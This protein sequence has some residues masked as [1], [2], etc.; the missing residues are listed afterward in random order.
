MRFSKR[1]TIFSKYFSRNSS[2]SPLSPAATGIRKNKFSQPCGAT[3]SSVT[4]VA[5]T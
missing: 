3:L 1:S 4:E 2:V 5:L